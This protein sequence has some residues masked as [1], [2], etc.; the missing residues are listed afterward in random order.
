[1]FPS[2]PKSPLT[3]HA[4]V[5]SRFCS[6]KGRRCGIPLEKYKSLLGASVRSVLWMTHR[7]FTQRRHANVWAGGPMCTL[8]RHSQVL[9]SAC[10]AAGNPPADVENFTHLSAGTLVFSSFQLKRHQL[11]IKDLFFPIP[12]TFLKVFV[13]GVPAPGIRA[14]VSMMSQRKTR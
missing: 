4:S 13:Q 14:G 7:L 2:V 8:G 9:E 10:G 6:S 1:M 5:F 3:Q 12:P 11:P